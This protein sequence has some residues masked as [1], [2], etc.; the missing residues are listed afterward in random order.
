MILDNDFPLVSVGIP[1]FNRVAGLKR[2]LAN[3]AAQKYRNLEIIVSD[4]CSPN[5]ESEIVVR[6]FM[7]NDARISYYKQPVN[8]GAWKNFQFVL[9]KSRGEYF[10]WAAD[11][12]EWEE[13][14]V[15]QCLANISGVSSVMCEFE[16]VFRV[17]K[18]LVK[19]PIPSLGYSGSTYSDASEFLKYIQPSLIYGLH[20]RTDIQFVLSEE[21]FDFYDC[22]FVLRIILEHGMRTI[23]GV[24]YRAGVDEPEYQVKTTNALSGRLNYFPFVRNV[25]N[26]VWASQKLSLFQKINISISF[27]GVIS[28]LLTQ[29]KK[30]NSKYINLIIEAKNALIRGMRFGKRIY[31]KVTGC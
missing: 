22:Y 19:N 26:I 13:N 7:Q 20:K 16:T 11:D 23:S 30:Y 6:E 25:L 3:I 15:T 31:K 8:L 4:N 9:E 24:S 29:H 1:T 14:F 2:T 18:T 27:L 21:V 12:D 5:S 28:G 10:M 17:Q